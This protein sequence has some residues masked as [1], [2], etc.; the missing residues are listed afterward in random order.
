M[1]WIRIA[2]EFHFSASHELRREDL[3]EKDNFL[4][5]GKCSRV[6]GHNYILTV[7]V[8]GQVNS[9]T[10]MVLNYFDLSDIVDKNVV[11][12]W[13]HYHLNDRMNA[14]PTAENMLQEVLKK[15]ENKFPTGVVLTRVRIQE[16]SKTYAEWW[17]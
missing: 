5:F 1:S 9:D 14:L 2:K 16:T 3:S 13:D 11:A 10:G 4:T 7:E 6:H 8:S 12:T 15:L 17:T